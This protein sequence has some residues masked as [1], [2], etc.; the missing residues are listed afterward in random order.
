[1]NCL[2]ILVDIYIKLFY[3]IFF[4]SFC[5]TIYILFFSEQH[6]VSLIPLHF[7]LVSRRWILQGSVSIVQGICFHVLSSLAVSLR[8]DDAT[9]PKTNKRRVILVTLTSDA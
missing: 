4:I 8:C 7:V 2:I 6:E 5:L 1:M 3:F 9:V